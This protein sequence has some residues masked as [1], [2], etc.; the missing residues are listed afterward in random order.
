MCNISGFLYSGKITT[1]FFARILP[2]LYT[3]LY[4]D[5][6][7]LR[8]QFADFRGKYAEFRKVCSRLT[9]AKISRELQIKVL[10][11]DNAL[12]D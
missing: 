5:A 4:R 8:G 2:W 10:S 11:M 3:V 12:S 9:K 1:A 6:H 7:W